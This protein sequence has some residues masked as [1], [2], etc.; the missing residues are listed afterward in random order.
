MATAAKR[1]AAPR[2]DAESRG[3]RHDAHGELQ[4]GGMLAE[5][6]K[7]QTAV[8]RGILCSR[9]LPESYPAGESGRDAAA[10]KAQ[11]QVG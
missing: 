4:K 1:G 10:R 8:S 3:P 5:Y 7:C 2:A 11:R 9:Q 6:H